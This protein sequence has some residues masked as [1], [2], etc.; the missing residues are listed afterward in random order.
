MSEQ[1]KNTASALVSFAHGE[2]RIA[3]GLP[4]VREP[5]PSLLDLVLR[6]ESNELTY[7][8]T[9]ALF[10][11]LIRTGQAWSLQGSY[12]RTAVALIESGYITPEGI[13]TAAG[14]AMADASE[15]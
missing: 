6:H 7:A 9:L 15:W 4:A 13:V 5:E 8:E 1:A 12:G 3:A 2:A 14:Q 10:A 11:R